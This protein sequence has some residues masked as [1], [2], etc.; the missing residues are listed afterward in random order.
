MKK[1][2][3]IG[4]CDLTLDGWINLD[5][6]TEH[7]SNKQEKIDINHNLMRFQ[8]IPLKNKS[9]EIVATFH[10]I[11]HLLNKNV[12]FLFQEVYRMLRSGGTFRITCPDIGGKIFEAYKGNNR[13]YISNWMIHEKNKR[14][15]I[16]NIW[17]Q[18]GIGEQFLY[19]FAGYMSPFHPVHAFR[20]DSKQIR[21]LKS[22]L[23]RNLDVKVFE[24][25]EIKVMART[26]TRDDFLD[27]FVS[28]YPKYIKFVQEKFPG[29]HISWWGYEKIKK[30]L[31]EIGFKDIKQMDFGISNLTE[32]EKIDILSKGNIEKKDYTVF[33][34]C[35]K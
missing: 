11:E 15:K 22:F 3:N 35:E 10:T 32:L 9:L 6:K 14:Q 20:L 23:N 30:T 28:Q 21:E 7:Y 4:S 13:E 19:I 18:F 29:T 34:E 27:F 12:E 31:E 5:F 16:W 24:E 2:L 33:V 1:Y 25:H 8:Q 26:K 17:N